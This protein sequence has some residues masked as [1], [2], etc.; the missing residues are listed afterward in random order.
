MR[1]GRRMQPVDRLGRDVHR[2]IEP[3]GDV[4]PPDVVVDRLGHAHHV[5]PHR[6]QPARRLLRPV[7]AD[8]DQAIQAQLLIMPPDRQ[9]LVRVPFR[10]HFP[11]GL[12]ARGAQ[13][14]SPQVQDPGEALL[15]ERLIVFLHQSLKPTM[16][17]DDLHA[18]VHDRRLPH[19]TDR[20]VDAR[21][22]A[23]R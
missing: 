21:A 6:R 4:G 18:V 22:I 20:G 1:A 17:A 12:L 8:T 19:A 9:G 16:N 13:D 3:E 14:G 11:E 23:A 10:Q 5:Q 2:R 7:T 15:V